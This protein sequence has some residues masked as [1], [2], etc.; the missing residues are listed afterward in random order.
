[1]ADILSPIIILDTKIVRAVAYEPEHI[2][3]IWRRLKERGT[4]MS[5][6][7]LVARFDYL[8]NRAFVQLIYRDKTP[9]H[10]PLIRRNPSTP[11]SVLQIRT[12]VRAAHERRLSRIP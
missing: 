12:L 3:I 2:G 1:M 8:S 7:A 5:V 9:L 10:L 11:D 4:M 6:R